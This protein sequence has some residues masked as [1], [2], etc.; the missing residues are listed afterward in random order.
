MS[1]AT[2][3][4]R[5]IA[6]EISQETGIEI[7][8]HPVSLEPEHYGEDEFPINRFQWE[9]ELFKLFD[10]YAPERDN[11]WR[12]HGEDFENDTFWVHL[13]YHF[14]KCKCGYKDEEFSDEIL[15]KDHL[16]TCEYWWLN[17]PNFFHKPSGY[18]VS[19]YKYPCREA[20]GNQPKTIEEFRE[21]IQECIRSVKP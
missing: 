21:I 13:D 12:D 6:V 11:S 2:E 7:T 3:V 18:G 14:F 10:T 5:K 16:K 15:K 19:W 9:T 1:K 20:C 8:I 17:K 4:I